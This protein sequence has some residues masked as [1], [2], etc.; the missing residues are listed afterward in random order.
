MKFNILSDEKR[1][2][3]TLDVLLKCEQALEKMDLARKLGAAGGSSSGGG[4]APNSVSASGP[5]SVGP[6]SNPP[7]APTPN[8]LSQP[9]SVS[10]PEPT[11]GPPSVSGSGPLSGLSPSNQALSRTGMPLS[12]GSQG[13]M[14]SSGPG[15]AQSQNGFI[16]AN[17]LMQMGG[18]GMQMPDHNNVC[19]PLFETVTKLIT[20]P[21]FSHTMH[22][23]FARELLYRSL[24]IRIVVLSKTILFHL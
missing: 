22:R 13:G 6:G 21:F 15:S 3:V 12:A 9:S 8:V 1:Q 7:S 19:A 16:G 18:G 20:K 14:Q 24:L 23:T 2:N 10:L 4:S 5:G 17:Q 11:S